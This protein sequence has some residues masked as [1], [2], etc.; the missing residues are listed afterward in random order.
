MHLYFQNICPVRG[1]ILYYSHGHISGL[2]NFLLYT[3]IQIHAV[4]RSTVR[5]YLLDCIWKMTS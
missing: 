5:E 2:A 1:D 4:Q 3:K